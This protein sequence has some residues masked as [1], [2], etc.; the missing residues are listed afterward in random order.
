MQSNR[1]LS[2][3]LNLFHYRT[4]SM[5]FVLSTGRTTYQGRTHYNECVCLF[6]AHMWVENVQLEAYEKDEVR[7]NANARR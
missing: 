5:A 7:E 4:S 2:F 3:P 1:F 6:N